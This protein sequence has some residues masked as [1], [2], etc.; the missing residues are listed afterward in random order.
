M[1][2]MI[3]REAKPAVAGGGKK[4]KLTVTEMEH[5]WRSRQKR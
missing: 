1:T 4:S 5:G 3:R 2:Q